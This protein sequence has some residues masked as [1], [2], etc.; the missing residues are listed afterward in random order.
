[1]FDKAAVHAKIIFEEDVMPGDTYAYQKYFI[2]QVIAYQTD[3]ETGIR[4]G[5]KSVADTFA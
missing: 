1:M 4:T 3:E 2:Q 5:R